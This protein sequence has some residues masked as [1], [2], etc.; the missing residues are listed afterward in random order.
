MSLLMLDIVNQPS[1]N[2]RSVYLRGKSISKEDVN[3]TLGHPVELSVLEV[4]AS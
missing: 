4:G 2:E 3:E 1:F